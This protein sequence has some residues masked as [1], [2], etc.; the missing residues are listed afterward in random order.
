MVVV[1][2]GYDFRRRFGGRKEAV[3]Y[4]I[5]KLLWKGNRRLRNLGMGDE[6]RG[7]VIV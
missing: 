1:M 5:Q 7:Q 6:G 3:K 4:N 2:L